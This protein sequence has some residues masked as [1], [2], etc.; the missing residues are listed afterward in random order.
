M[1]RIHNHDTAV[2]LLKVYKATSNLG[3]FCDYYLSQFGG[4]RDELEMFWEL[5]DHVVDT[6]ILPLQS[7]LEEAEGKIARVLDLEGQDGIT[8]AKFA[9]EALSILRT[10]PAT[11]GE[12][13]K[14]KSPLEATGTLGSHGYQIDDLSPKDKK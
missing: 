10:P 8:D 12:G 13:V 11:K 5:I 3:L 7:K 4:S 9:E 14:L 2:K 1:D 6:D